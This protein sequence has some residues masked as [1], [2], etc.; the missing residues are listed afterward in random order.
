MSFW[1]FII[2][3][4][5]TTIVSRK[6]RDVSQQRNMRLL[7]TECQLMLSPPPRGLGVPMQPSRALAPSQVAMQGV[8]F[9][10]FLPPRGLWPWRLPCW[11]PTSGFV[12]KVKAERVL[13]IQWMWR[14]C[15]ETLGGIF[16][17]LPLT[18][19]KVFNKHDMPQLLRESDL[20]PMQR[21]PGSC[22]FI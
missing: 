10:F 16:S 15:S 20:Q 2:T 7:H 11:G 21:M 17:T 19:Q 3:A 8:N 6:K 14:S 13:H 9:V 22:P 5:N 1:A 12:C 4:Q 18:N